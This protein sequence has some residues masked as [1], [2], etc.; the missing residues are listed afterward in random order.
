MVQKGPKGPFDR[1]S[2]AV[3]FAEERR[4]PRRHRVFV[5]RNLRLPSIGAIG[6]DLDHTLAHY[7]P[8]PVEELAFRTT[9]Q[10]LV[11]KRGYPNAI[12]SIAYDPGFVIR[13]LVVD[14][15]RG[16]V[17]KADYHGYVTRG[18]HGRR[19]I[20]DEKLAPYRRSR[21]SFSSKGYSSV[22]TLFHVP[23]VYLYLAIVDVLEDLGEKPDYAKVYQDV[24][25]TIDQAHADGS[26]KS[27]IREDPSRFVQSDARIVPI[28]ERFRSWGKRLFLLTNSE[29]YYT[30]ILM[31][32][33][34]REGNGE[35]GGEWA[36]LFDVIVTD[37]KKPLF[38]GTGRGAVARPHGR[39]QHPCAMKG[40]DVTF[41]EARLGF[42]GDRILYFGDHTYGDILRAKKS[43]GWRTAMVVLE[44]ERELRV[45]QE[46]EPRVRAYVA[47]TEE[48][49]R[50]DMEK[51]ALERETARL[52]LLNRSEVVARTRGRREAKVSALSEE[53]RSRAKK[54]RD[55][56]RKI[57]ALWRECET[58]YNPVW[59]PVFREGKETSRFGHQVKDFACL[60]TSRV[61]NFLN[62]D[63]G[64]YFRS[65]MELMPH[66]M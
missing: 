26:I 11:R 50:I 55:L 39:I 1:V 49:E 21:V 47:L 45:T 16:N 30:D 13:G 61:S 32:H 65:P 51:A 41:L 44:L 22:D 57:D 40:G 9:Q 15:R 42:R 58:S 6:F 36:A 3:S 29:F 54:L 52:E 66:E 17:L 18:C 10:R 28:L 33:L 19:T 2:S 31:R 35:E 8:I 59:G 27:V 14:W 64:H 20:P 34:F 23:E 60:Y 62:Y 63:G 7:D 5:N 24:R 43:A 25:E 4:I 56:T 38:F 12:A 46:I 37:A 53:I 48:R